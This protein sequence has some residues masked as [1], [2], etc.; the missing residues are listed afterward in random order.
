MKICFENRADDVNAILTIGDIVETVFPESKFDYE[1]DDNSV[2]FS[3]VYDRDFVFKTDEKTD[4]LTK[5]LFDNIGNLIVQIKNTYKVSDLADGDTVELYEKAHYV[6]TTKREA[7]W[8][9]IPALYY[10]AQAECEG[11]VVSV[12]GSAAANQAKF[13]K[14]YKAVLKV[15]NLNGWFR[16]LRYIKQMKRQKKICSDKVITEKFQELYAMSF[17]DRAYQFKPLLVIFDRMVDSVLDKIPKK[18]RLK[19]KGKLDEIR[20]LFK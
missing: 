1:T 3:V 13:I 6:P 18:I 17:D 12:E 7:F 16:I 8:R 11:A 19:L 15:L 9:C 4:R 10:F 5:L 20:Q 14:A 2:V